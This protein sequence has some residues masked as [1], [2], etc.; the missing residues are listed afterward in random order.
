MNTATASVLYCL[1]GMTEN[2]AEAIVNHRRQNG[3]FESIAH[4]LDVSGMT[5]DLFKQI[6]PRATIRSGTYRIHSEGLIPS[7]GARRRLHVVVRLGTFDVET[8]DY[9]E[10]P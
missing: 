4:L 8:L 1:P 7:T 10:D 3:P 6:E 2:L 5:V 9:R